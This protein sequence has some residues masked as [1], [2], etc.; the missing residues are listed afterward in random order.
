MIFKSTLVAVMLN[1]ALFAESDIEKKLSVRIQAIDLIL[2]DYE[3]DGVEYNVNFDYHVGHLNGRNQAYK[4][5]LDLIK[6]N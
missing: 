4:E 5:C 1:C 3:I 6:Q 2:S